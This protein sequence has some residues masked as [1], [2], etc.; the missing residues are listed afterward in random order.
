MKKLSPTHSSHKS[1]TRYRLSRRTSLRN[2]RGLIIASTLVIVTLIF[3]IS[4]V[5][6]TQANGIPSASLQKQYSMQQEISQNQ[7]QARAHPHTKPVQIQTPASQPAPVLH[8][9]IIQMHQGPFPSS[10]F[11][12]RNVWQGQINSEWILAYAGARTNVHSLSGQGG[13]VLYT[14]KSSTSGGFDVHRIGVFLAPMS[15]SPL[16]IVTLSGHFMTLRTDT[17]TQ[18][19]F[20]LQTHQYQ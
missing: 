9:G 2:F 4:A 17:G 12:V 10:I 6:R 1:T 14:E 18:L 15:T 8:G 19:I 7:A 16:T 13:V 20:N 3:L 5:N 11:T